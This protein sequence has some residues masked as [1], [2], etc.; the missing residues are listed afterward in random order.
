MAVFGCLLGWLVAGRPT[1]SPTAQ[2]VVAAARNASAP[3]VRQPPRRHYRPATPGPLPVGLTPLDAK[4]RAALRARLSYGAGPRSKPAVAEAHVIAFSST[5]TFFDAGTGDGS[6]ATTVSTAT[7]ET[8]TTPTVTVPTGPPIQITDVHTVSLSPFAATIAW[9]TSEPVDSRVAY[10]FGLPTLW[11]AS[12]PGSSHVATVTGLSFG[13]SYRVWVTAHAADGR[14]AEADYMLTTP[15]LSGPAQG[16]TGNG[17][18]LVD[19]QPIFPTIVWTQCPDSY[20]QDLA[21]GIDLF[22]GNGCGSDQQ[23]VN[24]LGNS[25]FYA[26]SAFGPGASGPGLVGS[27]LPDEWDT[28]MAGNLTAADVAQMIPRG[29]L[30]PRFLTLTNH[31]FSGAAPLP[32]GRGMYPGVV[33]NAD[34]LGF[35]LYPLQNWCRFDDFGVVYDSQR[36]LV[37]LAVGKPTFQWIEARHMDCADPTLDPTP[38]TV[39]AE[40]WLAIAGGAHA[41]GYF[42]YSWQPDVG[43]EIARERQ[44]IDALVPALLEPAIQAATTTAD[45]KVSA[46]DHNGALYVIAVNAHRTTTSGM[47]T[48]PGLGNRTLVSLDGTRSVTAANNSFNDTWGPLEVHVYIAAPQG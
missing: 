20:G 6:T 17:A 44:E 45:V 48:V 8:G 30:S 1:A 24:A 47:I 38:Q 46:R 40:T 13:K 9:Q 4:A 19:G 32:Q 25:A 37:Q 7:T 2:P 41:I 5:R 23:A 21:V 22:L 12:S 11:T 28:H 31:F 18:F 42:P 35:D 29:T 14:T 36:E 26:S 34:V 15:A 16:A 43:D 3:Q 39:R 33:A 10:G 27:Y